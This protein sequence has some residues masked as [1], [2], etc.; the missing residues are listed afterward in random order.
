MQALVLQ[1]S[2]EGSKLLTRL[3]SGSWVLVVER[4]EVQAPAQALGAVFRAGSGG[5]ELG[6]SRK[7]FLPTIGLFVLSFQVNSS[8]FSL[9]ARGCPQPP[10]T[11]VYMAGRPRAGG[12]CGD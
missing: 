1:D 10:R 5:L 3:Q 12:C 7:C 6:M 9:M 4:L 8:A 2:R 11:T